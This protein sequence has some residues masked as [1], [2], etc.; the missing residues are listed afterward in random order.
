MAPGS[1]SLPGHAVGL[2]ET[3]TLSRQLALVATAT[4]VGSQF[5]SPAVVIYC[6]DLGLLDMDGEECSD[7]FLQQDLHSVAYLTTRLKQMGPQ[8]G[9][10]RP[11]YRKHSH[12]QSRPEQR[13]VFRTLYS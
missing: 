12:M 13:N 9:R 2:C 4:A 8:W 3:A 7:A 10:S 1:P 5:A 11:V 6:C